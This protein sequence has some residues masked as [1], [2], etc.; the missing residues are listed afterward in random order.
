MK[1]IK[2]LASI[3]TG[4]LLILSI[5]MAWKASSIEEDVVSSG[6]HLV[7]YLQLLVSLFCVRI[8]LSSDRKIRFLTFAFALTVIIL[9]T[10]SWIQP[11]ELL[12]V[13]KVSLGILPILI[14]SALILL[15]DNTSKVSR[16]LQVLLGIIA[17]LLSCFVFV[18]VSEYTLYTT[19]LVGMVIASIGTVGVLIFGRPN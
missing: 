10:Y 7:F 2:Y 8:A 3:L 5:W 16:A 12:V 9:S 15:L 14:G 13:G 6:L 18:G 17:L 1:S 11:S 19:L 4:I